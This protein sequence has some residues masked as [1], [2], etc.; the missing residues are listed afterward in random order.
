M[1]EI[2]NL[3]CESSPV[4]ECPNCKS[5]EWYILLDGYGDNWQ[6][7]KGTECAGCGWICKWVVGERE[8]STDV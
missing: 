5:T 3:K 8:E 2:I 4:A 1:A 6:N 7:L